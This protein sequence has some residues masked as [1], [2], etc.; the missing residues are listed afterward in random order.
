MSK[1]NLGKNFF[2]KKNLSKIW[3]KKTF[4]EKICR[5]K[6]LGKN[7]FRKKIAKNLGINPPLVHL[8][9]SHVLITSSANVISHVNDHT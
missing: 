5:K 7:F 1:K 8:L 3:E 4:E 6:N 9:S 2:L